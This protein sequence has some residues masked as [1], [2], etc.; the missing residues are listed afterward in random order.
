MKKS[1]N[2]FAIGMRDVLDVKFSKDGSLNKKVFER[3]R[4]NNSRQK[5]SVGLIDV[6]GSGHAETAVLIKRRTP[7]VK[8][9][10]LYF[11]D[12]DTRQAY[13]IRNLAKFRI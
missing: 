3:I 4:K 13:E 5:E 9:K 8:V 10:H 12:S 2:E 11:L 1:E 7:E 6:F